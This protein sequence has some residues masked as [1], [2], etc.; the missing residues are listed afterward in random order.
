MDKFSGVRNSTANRLPVKIFD[1]SVTTG[2]GKTALSP[3]TAGLIIAVTAD[4][5]QG[6]SAGTG[7]GF[8]VAYTQAAGTIQGI[9][10]IGTFVAPTT[11]HVRFG[12][13]DPTNH[14]GDYE[15]QIED[16]R[17]AVAG[18][19]RLRVTITC[20][21]SGGAQYDAEIELSAIDY[22]DASGFDG[23]CPVAAPD[24]N[25]IYADPNDTIANGAGFGKA[26]WL[27][28]VG[29]TGDGDGAIITGATT[30][31]GHLE[32][33]VLSGMAFQ[34]APDVS[35][36]YWWGDF[37]DVRNILGT[38]GGGGGT[39]PWNTILPG[40]YP[41]NSAGARLAALP[42][43]VQ[44]QQQMDSGSTQ[45]AAL[46]TGQGTIL[47]AVNNINNVS[48]LIGLRLPQ[49]MP[50]P[51]TGTTQYIFS[52]WL[53]DAEGH[54]VNADGANNGQGSV[55]FTVKNASGTSLSGQLG[56]TTYGGVTGNYNVLYTVNASD[57][58]QELQV[59]VT[60]TV[61]GVARSDSAMTATTPFFATTFTVSDRNAIL[62]LPSAVAVRTEMDANSTQLAAI[63]T[64]V[65]PTLNSM[66][67]D[68]QTT[69]DELGA[70]LESYTGGGS[71]KRFTAAALGAT[72][73]GGGGGGGGGGTDPWSISFT[74]LAAYSPGTAGNIQYQIGLSYGL[75]I[76]A[77]VVDTNPAAG[78]FKIQA[79]PNNTLPMI[80]GALARGSAPNWLKATSGSCLLQFSAISGWVP[81]QDG[82]TIQVTLAT[83]FTGAVP[84]GGANN[85]ANDTVV[86][87]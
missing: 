10:Q 11:G 43:A 30:V 3:S 7:A 75:L 66:V 52:V 28:I 37:A 58:L 25:H 72:P 84:S 68:I 87:W 22:A 50:V 69:S 20:G 61:N 80:A 41:T 81:Q 29:G 35:T 57:A 82:I 14:P 1:N 24:V 46:V 36:Q 42:T 16:S 63:R 64:S 17:Y 62:A 45:F 26:R 71:L 38:G 67:T 47:T 73:T 74:A 59:G 60:A 86:I 32:M 65:G 5:E 18:S 76:E 4:N 6:P 2:A 13:V 51:S 78:T 34:V 49:Q 85:S 48:A 54:N 19:K 83:P 70:M 12:E 44:N 9:A 15:L 53:K 21:T 8:G 79:L 55:A 31:G 33:A 77:K 39:D 56:S 27:Y 23:Q 40:S